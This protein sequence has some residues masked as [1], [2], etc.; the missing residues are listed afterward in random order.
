MNNLAYS[1]QDIEKV[2]TKVEE[3]LRK[4]LGSDL[5]VAYTVKDHNAPKENLLGSMIKNL[6][7]VLFGGKETV[8]YTLMFNIDK[9]RPIEIH[10]QINK[11]GIGCHAGSILFVTH[12]NKTVA[13]NVTM[14]GPKMFGSSKFIG[15]TTASA[16]LNSNKELVKLTE[17]FARTKTDVAGGLKMDRHVL[18][19]PAENGSLLIIVT[20]PRATSMGMGATTDAKDF[21]T[22]ASLVE[23]TL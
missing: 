21:F 17:K 14:E 7:T 19:E 1:T 16:K 22:I 6:P 18:I 4:D 13:G 3:I 23:Q 8:L 5:P 12:I 15:D 2:G 20:L 11:Q 10:M 9:P